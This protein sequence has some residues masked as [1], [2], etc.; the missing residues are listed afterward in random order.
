MAA[1]IAAGSDVG[2]VWHGLLTIGR[3]V[4]ADTDPSAWL[5]EAG[6]A[7]AVA[8]TVHAAG[9]TALVVARNEGE[10]RVLYLTFDVSRPPLMRFR[11]G[12]G[13][14]WALAFR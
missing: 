12:T 4:A 11:S 9:G 6:F 5:L 1:V 7:R 14:T 2:A 8:G 13:S 10:G 3:V